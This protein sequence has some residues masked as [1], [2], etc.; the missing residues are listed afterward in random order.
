MSELVVPY[1][2]YTVSVLVVDNTSFVRN[3]NYRVNRMTSTRS[4]TVIF[5]RHY[6]PGPVRGK[7]GSR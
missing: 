4:W 3:E 1:G 7:K 6:L 2:I 5:P